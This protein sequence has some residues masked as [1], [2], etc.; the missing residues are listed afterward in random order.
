MIL[1]NRKYEKLNFLCFIN[2]LY[3]IDESKII[4]FQGNILLIHLLQ[5]FVLRAGKFI[6]FYIF[7]DTK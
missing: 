7:D 3:F 6:Q 1:L 4:I 5:T 2:L